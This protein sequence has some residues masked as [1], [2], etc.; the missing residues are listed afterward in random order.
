STSI[1]NTPLPEN[2]TP[3]GDLI[4]FDKN[5]PTYYLN[6][7]NVPVVDF[8]TNE[9]IKW[10]TK[11]G[12]K[13]NKKI[14]SK[15]IPKTEKEWFDLM[16]SN[17][18]KPNLDIEV[19]WP[20]SFPDNKEHCEFTEIEKLNFE[21]GMTEERAQRI[22]N[23]I[24]NYEYLIRVKFI[25]DNTVISVEKTKR[26]FKI[27]DKYEPI[28]E[29]KKAEIDE[30]FLVREV[31]EQSE[32]G[33]L[34]SN[35][36]VYGLYRI[37]KPDVN[38]LIPMKNRALNWHGLTEI[39]RQKI[40]DW[41]KKMRI[42]GAR[43]QDVAELEKILK[44]PITLLDIT[45]STIFNR[46]KYRSVE[47]YKDNTWKAIN[48]AFQGPQ[49]IWLMGVGDENQRVSQFV[50]EDGHVFRTWIKYTDII[51]AYKELFEDMVNW[52]F[53]KNIINEEK[54]LILLKSLKVVDLAEQVFG[55]NHAGSQLANEINKWCP[56][57][58]KINDVIRQACVEHGHGGR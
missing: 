57:S 5:I 36:V 2:L 6:V 43:V 42:P 18:N 24:D 32:V 52:Q 13:N 56:I 33:K 40:N 28:C 15:P 31:S 53:H 34:D 9:L 48:N 26:G 35:A 54:K 20:I 29:S 58:E 12:I 4:S 46:K 11:P 44:Q 14:R 39:R 22:L 45:H 55:A 21:A 50:L 3:I 38:R 8:L 30:K 41:E 37:R 25:R 51:K 7:S 10:L 27:I 1:Q 49:T 23:T 16:E 19:L 17:N 47:Y